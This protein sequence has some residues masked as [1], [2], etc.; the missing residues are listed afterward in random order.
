[1]A[2]NKS[3]LPPQKRPVVAAERP[4]G[5]GTVKPTKAKPIGLDLGG[6]PRTFKPSGPTQIGKGIQT[7]ALAGGGKLGPK[8]AKIPK[9]P[10]I[11]PPRF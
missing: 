1:M 10:T 9:I 8:T 3:G 6:P 2:L 5:F 11:K 7:D 4:G